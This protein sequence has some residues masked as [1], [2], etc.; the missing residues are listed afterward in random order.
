MRFELQLPFP[1]PFN[2]LT[3][4]RFG[5]PRAGQVRLTVHDP[6]G[7]LVRVLVDGSR[8]AG[9]IEETWDGRNARGNQV[10]SGVY[11]A[12]LDGSDGQLQR[13]LLLLK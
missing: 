4:L 12:R 7:R 9:W 8:P 11:F 5:N 2:P 10:A 6:T 13:K 1:N 3:T